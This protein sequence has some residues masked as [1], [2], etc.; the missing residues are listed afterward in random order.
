MAGKKHGDFWQHMN[1][2]VF[3]GQTMETDEGAVTVLA[4]ADPQKQE[5]L[6]SEFVPDPMEGEQTW[7]TEEELAEAESQF[8]WLGFCVHW[9]TFKFVLVLGNIIQFI[10]CDEVIDFTFVSSHKRAPLIL[11]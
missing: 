3:Q 8:V 11:H 2:P 1:F 5:S 9:A 4:R 7:P 6:Q 10:A